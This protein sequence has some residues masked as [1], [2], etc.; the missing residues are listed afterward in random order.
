M[1]RAM[2][3]RPSWPAGQAAAGNEALA[4]LVKKTPDAIGY[5]ELNY[6]IA[7]RLS[8]GPVQ[9]AAGKF[10][11]PDAE[12]LGAAEDMAQSMKGD[13]RGSIVNSPAKNAYPISTLTWLIVPSHISD[14]R[15]RKAT[16][17]FLDWAY[18]SGQKIANSMDY[19]ELQAPLIDRVR[20]QVSAIH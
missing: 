19:D 11:R 2:M 12:V 4:E 3:L 18:K 16:R 7:Q 8:Y 17:D 14:E 13:F 6:A 9:N 10:Q 1:V 20:D 5:V 15:K